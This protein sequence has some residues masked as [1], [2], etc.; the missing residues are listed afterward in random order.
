MDINEKIKPHLETVNCPFCGSDRARRV[1]QIADIAKCE[2]C[3]SVYLRT[4]LNPKALR[5]IYQSYGDEGSHMHP[6]K[7]ASKIDENPLRRKEFFEEISE[8]VE[9]GGKLIDVGCGW[10]AFLDYA[11]SKGYEVRGVE[12]SESVA[13]YGVENL[14][15][16]IDTDDL[17]DLELSPNSFSVATMIHTLEHLPEPRKTLEK[18]FNIL[19]PGGMLCGIV[20]NFGSYLSEK[21]RD[22][23]EW[24]DPYRHIVQFEQETIEQALKQAGFKIEKI[25]TKTGDYDPAQLKSEIVRRTHES[26]PVSIE[27]EIEELEKSGK[28]EEIRFFARKPARETFDEISEDYELGVSNLERLKALEKV[29]LHVNPGEDYERIL[30]DYLKNS[31]EAKRIVLVDNAGTVPDYADNWNGVEIVRKVAPKETEP[32]QPEIELQNTSEIESEKFDESDFALISDKPQAPSD[33][34]P[35]EEKQTLHEEPEKSRESGAENAN[36]SSTMNRIRFENDLEGGFSNK[37]A[38]GKL[39]EPLPAPLLLNLGCGKDL[40]KGFVNIDLYSDDP[41]VIGMDVRKLELPDESTDLILASDILEHF[42]HREIDAVLAEWARVLKPGG[43]LLIRCPSLKLQA[44]AYVEGIWNADVASYMIFGGQTNPGDYHCVAFDDKSIRKRLAKAGLETIELK[45]ENFPQDRGY[46]NLNMTVKAMKP[47]KKTGDFDEAKP[48]VEIESE[49]REESFAGLSFGSEPIISPDESEE[50]P[51]PEKAIEPEE[52]PERKASEP[53]FNVVWEG[54]QFV[55]H[56][57][58]LINRE[59]CLNL[60]D[61]GAVETTIV[62]FEEDKFHHSVKD[63]YKK[64]LAADVRFKEDPPKDIAKLPYAWI[65]HTWPPQID[66]PKG[67]KWI[68][69]QPWEY[70]S[71]IKKF[72]EIFE[73]ADEIWTPSTFSRQTFLDAG[74]DFDKVQVIANGVDPELFKPT[75]DKYPLKTKKKFKLLFLGGTIFRKGFDVLLRAYA[76]RFNAQDDVCLVVKDMGGE[77]FYKG[78]TAEEHIQKLQE[79]DDSPEIEYIAESDLTEEKIA[80]I[81][82]ACD[83]FVCSYRGEGFSLPTLEAMACGLPVIVTDGGAT[84]D[85]VDEEVGFLIPAEKR[86]IGNEIDGLELTDEAFVLEPDEEELAKI[87][88][89][90]YED[91]SELKSIGMVASARARE[92]FTWKKATLKILARLDELYG[93]DAGKQATVALSERADAYVLLGKAE[94]D[95]LEGDSESASELFDKA[96]SSGELDSGAARHALLRLASIDLSD[97]ELDDAESKLAKA[98]EIDPFNVDVNY[99]KAKIEAIKG[100]LTVALET[101]TMLFNDWAEIKFRTTLGITLDDLLCDTADCFL[102]TEDVENASKLYEEALRINP[103]NAAACYGAAGCFMTVDAKDEARNMLEWALKID[104]DFKE[105]KE[106]MQEID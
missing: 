47:I 75:G 17:L 30:T 36:Y 48:D 89:A 56:S 27:K 28:G 61:S 93:M 20:P 6:P 58:A 64:L 55:Y 46:I 68:V 51:T 40:R 1:R 18:L 53:R 104:P 52:I 4:R 59:H 14:D 106:M 100:N 84:D 98:L 85:F 82:R 41:N 79:I 101:L 32:I 25:Y 90:V 87:L 74:I 99:F 15:I 88:G 70:T 5:A 103:N 13:A 35:K 81:Y 54:S 67:A 45:E 37:K 9:P 86:S 102:E 44:E 96:I 97:D 42:S 33:E 76:R 11:R 73:Q 95:F 72:M 39:P 26:D 12:P 57:F 66:R 60:I 65:R 71:H 24:I 3:G 7:D 94:R 77:A 21:Q 78:Q 31:D 22:A 2:K 38:F 34:A 19:K 69:M 83:A 49:E 29:E 62:P 63:K 91:P 92:S 80:S 50:I 10:G 105:A 23:W 43:K 8:F 16:R